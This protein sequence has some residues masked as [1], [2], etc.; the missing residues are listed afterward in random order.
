MEK[1]RSIILKTNTVN[2]DNLPYLKDNNQY[3]GFSENRN[4][5][6]EQLDRLGL[7]KDWADKI[8]L[9]AGEKNF[10]LQH[11][12][13]YGSDR[14]TCYL[15]LEWDKENYQVSF[16]DAIVRKPIEVPDKIIDG[17]ST[18]GLDQRMAKISWE[19]E[20]CNPMWRHLLIE[21]EHPSAKTLV[22]EKMVS[23][24][25]RLERAGPEGKDISERL[26]LK[27]WSE[28]DF[29]Q[30]IDNLYVLQ[31]KYEVWKRFETGKGL[32]ITIPEAYNLLNGHAVYKELLTE[33]GLTGQW[34][35]LNP[36]KTDVYGFNVLEKMVPGNAVA[37]PP[38]IPAN[39]ANTI[40]SSINHTTM[41]TDNLAY[42]KD[43][44]KYMGFGENMHT[45]LEKNIQLGKPDFQLR[46][47]TEINKKPFEGTLQFRKSGQSD[48]YFLNS[49]QAS[50]ERSNGEKTGQTFYLNKGKGVTAKEA[51]N[52]LEGRA[53]HKELTTKTGEP[54][55]AWIQLD[56]ENK[57]KHNNYEV[58]QY[59]EN[60]GYDVKVAAAKYA[61]AELDG[62]DKE[63]ALL[64]SLQKGNIQSV[65]VEN[66]GT[67]YK[68]FI[69]ANPQ[70]KTVN[71]YDG[72][73]K[74][75]QKEGMEQYLSAGQSQGKELQKAI[76]KDQAQNVV[77]DTTQQQVT[78]KPEQKQIR[79]RSKS[80]A[81]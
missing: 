40:S 50:L 55:K 67:T 3:M 13:Q 27:Y 5:V 37:V 34:Y 76:K 70:Y 38:N 16:Y 2:T 26:Q 69:E 58:K 31:D 52:L 73:M 56:F 44:I 6:L 1:Q 81:R 68:M 28:G 8:Q 80:Q 14:M 17:I 24:V 43:N 77:K 57:D 62:G 71:L 48:M 25:F 46:Y 15:Y 78:V 75:V 33:E 10:W 32:D 45:E 19:K 7:G 23:D 22:I 21:D 18:A 41:N 4:A 9:H 12:T 53:V 30:L 72:Q 65:T 11:H 49:Y 36:G 35:Q 47:Q 59:H 64:Q 54:Y 79:S 60:Y 74:R 42:L 51:Y 66:N 63:R 39:E 61:I 29:E 20:Y